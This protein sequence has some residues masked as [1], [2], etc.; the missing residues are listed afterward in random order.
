[1]QEWEEGLCPEATHVIFDEAEEVEQKASKVAIRNKAVIETSKLSKGKKI[2]LIMVLSSNNGDYLRAKN[3]KGRSD[4]FVEVELA[5]LVDDKPEDVLRLL[6]MN[7]EELATNALVLE[8]LQKHVFEKTGHKIMYHE[9]VL[10]QDIY[11]VTE[12][13]NAPE[14]Q[15]FKVRILAQVN[16]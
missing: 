7:K 12:Y 14:N 15:E 8:A 3:M 10:G 13:L 5:K 16:E 1:M 9:S 11:D 4:N 2:E 6:K